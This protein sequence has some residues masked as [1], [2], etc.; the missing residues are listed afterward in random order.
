MTLVENASPQ[1]NEMRDQEVAAEPREARGSSLP[2]IF[3]IISLLIWFAFQTVQLVFERTNLGA[4]KSNLEAPMQELQKMQSQLQSL[5][6]KTAEL[7]N[8][9][10]PGAKA[11]VEELEKRGIPIRSAAPPSK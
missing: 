2:L 4:L 8:Q 9:G 5:I 3:T 11:V 1:L 7:A 10:N 6:T